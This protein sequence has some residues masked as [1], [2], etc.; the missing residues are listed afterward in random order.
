M[1][2]ILIAD[3]LSA[4]TVD[5]LNEIPEFETIEIASLSPERL[6]GEIKNADAIITSG[7]SQLP[8]TAMT[9]AAN[10]KIVI[11]TGGE[12]NQM[13]TDTANGKNIEIRS[14]P[15]LQGTT[16]RNPEP[17]GSAVITILKDFFNV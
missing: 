13:D 17:E 12:A 11:L 7:I 4:A 8:P 3:Q 5:K 10:L 1:I 6:S 2:R 14:I 9:G 16:G 15:L